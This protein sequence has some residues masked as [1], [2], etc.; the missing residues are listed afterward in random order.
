[1]TPR[2]AVVAEA[3]TW[4]RTPYHHQ[5]RVRGVGVDCA[6]FPAAVYEAA[7]VIEHVDPRYT[8]DWHLHRSDELYLEWARSLAREIPEEEAGPGDFVIWKF[9]RT[10]SHGG[11][12]LDYPTVIHSYIGV[13]VSTDNINQHEE[14]RT[15]PRVF[16]SVWG[17]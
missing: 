1:M 10:F 15:R 3:L 5:A 8:R 11:I 6:Q 14:L 16:F 9:G 17:S 7:G 4:L 13:G 2:E 12:M